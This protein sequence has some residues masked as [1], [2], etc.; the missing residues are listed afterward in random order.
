MSNDQSRILL[1]EDEPAICASMS[2][3][4]AE[5]GYAVRCAEDGFVALRE[6]S[7]E[8]PEF[9]LSDLNMPGMSGFELLSVVR[10]RFPAIQT[11]AM[12]G[13]FAGVEVPPGIVADAFYPKGT[14]VQALLDIL[15]A[16]PAAQRPRSETSSATAPLWIHQSSVNPSPEASITITCPECLRTFPQDLGGAADRTHATN[17]LYC[18]SPIHFA[19]VHTADVCTLAEPS[20]K[21]TVEN[22]RRPVYPTPNLY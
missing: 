4:L 17:C 8:M 1:V 7:Q 21:F 2:L 9:L 3:V 5:F 18:H 22:E 13:A 20:R 14:S 6:I 11:I 10:R 19:V 15:Q 16:L 12:S